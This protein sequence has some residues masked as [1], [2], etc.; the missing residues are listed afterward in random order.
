M[1]QEIAQ[2]LLETLHLVLCR[3]DFAGALFPSR[4]VGA[5]EGSLGRGDT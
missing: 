4:L 3:E 1:T 5:S 2:Q